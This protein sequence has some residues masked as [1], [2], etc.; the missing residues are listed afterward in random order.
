M[1]ELQE[2][3]EHY[4]ITKLIREYCHGC[5]RGDQRLMASVYADDS[6]D[7]HGTL[8]LPGGEFA[9][10]IMRQR[11]AR[12]DTMSHH[13]GQ[14]QVRI[15]GDE[16]GA[17]TYFVATVAV[18]D[19]ESRTKVHHLGGRYVDDLLRVDG[20]WRVRRRLTVR[21]WSYTVTVAEDYMGTLEFIPGSTDGDDPS[22]EAL[23]K[24]HSARS[25]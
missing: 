9:A 2:M 17:E 13:L 4:R 19:R 15:H 14:T 5:D 20:A 16:A 12:D 8:K 25:A 3:L 6:W 22:V 11:A 21:D 18:R 23:G 10:T 1:D 7:D 24:V